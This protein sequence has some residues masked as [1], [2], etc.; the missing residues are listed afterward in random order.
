MYWHLVVTDC[1]LEHC[2]LITT[3]VSLLESELKKKGG[4]KRN[5][6]GEWITWS[7]SPDCIPGEAGLVAAED[8]RLED[9]I[10]G[11]ACGTRSWAVGRSQFA[12]GCSDRLHTTVA[13]ARSR[14]SVWFNYSPK[15]IKAYADVA[16]VDCAMDQIQRWSGM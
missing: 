4:G 5:V 11:L 15:S 3:T 7:S 9:S 10:L 2:N 1:T 13:T 8:I 6:L 12:R 14:T 16:S